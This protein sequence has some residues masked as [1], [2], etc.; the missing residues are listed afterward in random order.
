MQII[1]QLV[2]EMFDIF[3]TSFTAL[4]FIS[5]SIQQ[6]AMQVCNDFMMVFKKFIHEMTNDKKNKK[7]IKHEKLFKLQ[8]ILQSRSLFQ[9]YSILMILHEDG[10]YKSILITGLT[11]II[12]A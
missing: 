12:I 8:I 6:A 4:I 7:R 9:Q 1:C 5:K 2:F 11:V 10:C 3:A